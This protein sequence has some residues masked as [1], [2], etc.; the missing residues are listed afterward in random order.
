MGREPAP[1]QTIT[2]YKGSQQGEHS[3]SI[4]MTTYPLGYLA[5]AWVAFEDIHPD[6]G[7]LVY[8]PASHRLP[9]VFSEDVGISTDD[10]KKRGYAPYHQR[11][12]PRI[13]EL[14]SEHGLQAHYFHAK[15]GDVLIWHANLIHGGSKRQNLELSRRGL[16]PQRFC[17]YTIGLRR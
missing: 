3:D 4:H 16:I 10:F 17:N 5:A 11:Y 9:Y 15:K 13:K 1:F 8:Y 7:P 12:E 14:I 6:S 2:S